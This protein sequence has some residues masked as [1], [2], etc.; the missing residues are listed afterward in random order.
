[1]STLLAGLV[2][3][4][5]GDS[6]MVHRNYL[7]DQLHDALT[8]D[9]ATVYSFGACGATPTDFL[10]PH[11]TDCGRASRLAG[12]A[13][14]TEEGPA[15][16]VWN[17]RELIARYH[18]DRVVIVM[19][20]TMGAYKTSDFPKAWVWDQVSS[21]TGELKAAQLACDWVGPPWGT[22]GGSFG[23]TYDK[24]R[25]LSDYLS[26]LVAPC[27]Y[28]DSTRFAKPGE[29]RTI[30]GQHLNAE[31]YK[32]W[33]AGIAGAVAAPAAAPPAAPESPAGGAEPW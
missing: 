30:D 28:I 13:Q 3:L 26:G 19:G 27:R 6:H 25:Q 15:L 2:V 1:M 31:G 32:A 23:K 5:I 18:P 24:V 33:A 8:A 14:K 11:M 9:G 20:D 17:A 22:E 7:I 10:V 16:P 12:G 21:L 29:W 4:V